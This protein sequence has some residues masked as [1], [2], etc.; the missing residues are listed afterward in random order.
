MYDQGELNKKVAEV[1]NSPICNSIKTIHY[2]VV[3]FIKWYNTI[4][5]STEG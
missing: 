4:D 2:K 5:H 1:A 3:N